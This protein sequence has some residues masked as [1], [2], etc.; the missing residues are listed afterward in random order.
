MNE[1]R[2]CIGEKL[3]R[4]ED[5]MRHK[6]AEDAKKAEAVTRLDRTYTT[7]LA[8]VDFSPSSIE[9]LHQAISLTEHFNASL[10]VLYVV[11]TSAHRYAIEQH[12]RLE[13][14]PICGMVS[15]PKTLEFPDEVVEVV[16]HELREQAYTALRQLLFPH[17]AGY[18]LELRVVIGHPV[19]RIIETAVHDEVDLIVLG[20]HGHT[21][22]AL[23]A[24]G[25]V[26]VSVTCLAPCSVLTV[27]TAT[28]EEKSWLQDFYETYLP[29]KP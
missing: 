11:T 25:G 29:R 3:Q 28:A 12:Q 19:E 18:P 17:F 27:K 9:A 14:T 16:G 20:S 4:L 13:G 22:P 15:E 7:I 26:T 10:I 6:D 8:P 23:T 24:L 2:D 1:S 21:S 5:E